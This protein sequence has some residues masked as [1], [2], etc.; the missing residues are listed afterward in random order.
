VLV[1]WH[2][3]AALAE[4]QHGVITRQQLIDVGM[5]DSAIDRRIS[6]RQ[7]YVVHRGVYAVGHRRLT[8]DGRRMAAVLAA[9]ADALSHRAAA[10]IHGVLRSS[11]MEVTVSRTR[12]SLPGIRV[13]RAS[14]PGDELTVV[15]GIP[16]TGVSR[17]LFDLAAVLPR[18]GVE[19]AVHEVDVHGL[20]DVISLPDLVAR[21]PRR[22]GVGTIRAILEAGVE[23]GKTELEGRFLAL[24]RKV[25]LP[26]PEVNAYV[27]A[28]GRWHECD[29]LWRA[30]RLAVELDGRAVHATQRAFERDRARDRAMH[31]DGW[32]VV[33]I[34]WRQLDDEPEKI[35]ADLRRMLV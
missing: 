14:V 7:L 8:A 13:H 27:F 24:A 31:A 4:P 5:S 20:T 22:R 29:C 33:R 16:V 1:R 3:V 15:R 35:V 28:G 18:D 10:T 6:G 26:P 32:R 21:Y 23:V 11:L 34:T 12:R 9:R 2:G 17:T 30:K 19:R 25:G